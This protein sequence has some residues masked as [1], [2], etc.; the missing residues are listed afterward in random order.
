MDDIYTGTRQDVF[1]KLFR[2]C[3]DTIQWNTILTEIALSGSSVLKYSIDPETNQGA[4]KRE[5]EYLQDA[6]HLFK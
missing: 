6:I 1:D 4:F 2:N 3:V 5:N